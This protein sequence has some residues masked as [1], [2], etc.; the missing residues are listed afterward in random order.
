[1]SGGL[2]GTNNGSLK[3]NAVPAVQPVRVSGGSSVGGL[4][5]Y[6]QTGSLR[7]YENGENFTVN[8]T[9]IRVGR[10]RR[11]G[12]RRHFGRAGP[13]GGQHRDGAQREL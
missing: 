10:D 5:G 3:D 8:G 2:V 9:G 1:M 13:P 7:Q 12:A 4:V 6:L 11:G